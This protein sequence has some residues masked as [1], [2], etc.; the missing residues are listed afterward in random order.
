MIQTKENTTIHLKKIRL[1]LIHFKTFIGSESLYLLLLFTFC[2]LSLRTAFLA[3]RACN[4]KDT[5]RLPSSRSHQP[6]QA[7]PP[8]TS[9]FPKRACH[10]SPPPPPLVLIQPRSGASG[11]LGRRAF[12][13]YER[14]SRKHVYGADDKTLRPTGY[15]AKR[16]WLCS[17]RG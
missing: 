3:C 7:K 9:N 16:M 10:I 2:T 6:E 12:L 4:V 1:I 13:F 5:L 15:G 8:V 14:R 11:T 17:A